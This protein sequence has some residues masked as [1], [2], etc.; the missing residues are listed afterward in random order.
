M[1]LALGVSGCAIQ[2]VPVGAPLSQAPA[3]VPPLAPVPPPQAA[4]EVPPPPP[5]RLVD[6]GGKID[7][8]L[9]LP[10]SAPGRVGVLGHDMLDSAQ[11][12]MTELADDGMALT[13]KDTKGT[14]DG[15]AAAARKAV[16]EGAKLI[17][18]PLTAPE[19]EAVRP[20][21]LQ[22]GINVLA[23]SNVAQTAGNGV[24][25]LG[26]LPQDEVRRITRYAA[27]TGI[28]HFAV[29]AP[30]NAYGKLASDAFQTAVAD[31][32]GTL[33][34][35]GFYDP[36]STDLRQAAKRLAGTPGF[37][38]LLLPEPDAARLKTAAS[39]LPAY[40]I[41]PTKVRLLGIGGSGEG[42]EASNLGTEAT[43]NGG[44]F[45]APA[46]EARAGFEQ[47]FLDAFGRKPQRLATLA[48]DAVGVAAV[49]E[50]TPGAGFSAESI[51][52]PSGF[53]GAD[54]IF[55]LL[56]DGTAQRGLAVLQIERSGTS[57]ISP[58]PDTFEQTGQ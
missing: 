28:D 6:V 30:S 11:L 44:W 51:T 43:L 24:F 5:E 18:G 38:A 42:W 22:A 56:P 10:L 9:L 20:I 8:A 55:R 4:Q 29:L 48:Y 21:A 32:G 16:A 17:V 34:A 15:A 1:I 37:S 14:P 31:A 50:R 27:S 52:N 35:S 3:E 53:A 2:N 33:D 39:L 12:A 19:I 7:V 54:G 40:G 13:P 23:F 58:A 47:R 25:L 26:I 41:D 46:E 45:A 57:T 49:L 36:N